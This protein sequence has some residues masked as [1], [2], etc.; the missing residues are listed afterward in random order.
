[1]DAFLLT[2]LVGFSSVLVL[3]ARE[4]RQRIARLA[5]YLAPYQIERLMEG[6]TEGY[7]RAMGEKDAERSQQIWRL[8][9]TSEV[10]LSE[11]LTR[12]AKDFAQTPE[13]EARVSRWPFALPYATRLAPAATFD[14]RRA[15]AVHAEGVSRAMANTAG[16]STRDRAYTISAEL[17]LL[18]HTCHWYCKSRT[19]ASARMLARHQTPYPQ[20]VASVSPAT[21][22]AYLA[23][24]RS[25]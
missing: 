7:L 12:L 8:L 5:Q 6:L 2:F 14:M 15:L 23:L 21:R 13:P 24:T 10:Q 3:N 16:L 4:Q 20:L 18:Q 11:Q 22:E 25:Q 9:T 19:V 1:M 17:L